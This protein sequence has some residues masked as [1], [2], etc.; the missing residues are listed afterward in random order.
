[1]KMKR[2][3]SLVLAM[4]MSLAL[5]APAFAAEDDPDEGIM[6]LQQIYDDDNIISS[7]GHAQT[8]PFAATPGN[9]KTIHFWCRNYADHPMEILVFRTDV[10]DAIFRAEIPANG[11]TWEKDY[12]NSTADS[13]SYYIK[14]QIRGNY[15]LN[16]RVAAAQYY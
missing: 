2:F 13:A 16:C 7:N 8:I 5:A 11:G 15:A 1:M 6:P 10:A 9:G 14:F 12:T 3:L 4:V